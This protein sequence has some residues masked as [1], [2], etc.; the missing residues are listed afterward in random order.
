MEEKKL[1]QLKYLLRCPFCNEEKLTTRSG[2]SNHKKYCKANP[3]RVTCKGHKVSKET[4]DKIS[5]GMKKAHAEGRA[6]NWVGRKNLEHSYPEKWL[7]TILKNNFNMVEGKDYVCELSF[8]NYFLDFAWPE[9]KLCIE[10]DGSQH[11]RDELQIERDKKKDQYLKEENWI[12]LRVDWGWIKQNENIFLES[13]VDFFS[14]N[15]SRVFE[16]N[17]SSLSYAKNRLDKSSRYIKN[18]NNYELDKLGRGNFKKLSS[19]EIED[20]KNLILS[21]GIDLQKFGWVSQVSK[22]TGLTARQINKIV[23]ITNI[24]CFKRH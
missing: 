8:H 21:S 15:Q 5:K 23:N 11:L 24:K 7:S 3:N 22:I 12:E 10:V 6:C 14:K 4:K 19:K 18:K 1:G 20:R 2:F 9:K 16:V 17:Q 13:L